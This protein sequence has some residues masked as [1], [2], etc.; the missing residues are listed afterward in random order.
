MEKKVN[1]EIFEIAKTPAYTN[2]GSL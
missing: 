2:A 1:I